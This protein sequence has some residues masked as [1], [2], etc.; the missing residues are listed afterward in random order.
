MEVGA[1]EF[2]V[3]IDLECEESDYEAEGMDKYTPEWENTYVIQPY[4]FEPLAPL[5]SG[6]NTDNA[7]QQSMPGLNNIAPLDIG[8]LQ[9]TDWYVQCIVYKLIYMGHHK[10]HKT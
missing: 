9:H 3:E 8:R 2:E 6:E 7:T 1:S 4:M 5:S 10:Q